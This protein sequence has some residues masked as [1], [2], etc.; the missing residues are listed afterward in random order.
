MRIRSALPGVRTPGG[1]D[2][3]L[4][5]AWPLILSNGCWALQISLNRVLLSRAG[6]DC[7]GAAT[8]AAMLYWTPICLLQG[9]ASYSATFVAQYHG[10]GQPH[11]VGPSVWQALYFAVASGIAFLMLIPLAPTLIVLVGHPSALQEIE[12]T[13]FR[14]LAVNA[15]PV[16][17]TAAVSGFFVGRGESRTMLVVNGIGLTITGVLAYAWVS[18]R[19]GCPAW[20]VAG[21]GWAT[22]AG[23]TLSCLLALAWLFRP[24]HDALYATWSGRRLDLDLMSRLLSYGVPSGLMVAL[25]SLAATLFILIVGR[26]GQAELAATSIAFTINLITS[27][28]ALGLGQAVA[29]LVGQRLGED[30]PE[31][32]RRATW[33]GLELILI[34]TASVGV[35]FCTVPESLARSFR[36]EANAT[37]WADVMRHLPLLLRFVAVY[38]TVEG[39]MIVLSFALRG[40]GDTRF[41][42]AAALVLSCPVMVLPTWFAW[43]QGW[44]L[45]W[46]WTFASLYVHLLALTFLARFCRG[47][48]YLMRVIELKWGHEQAG[49]RYH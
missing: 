49:S 48:W 21:A 33:T 30:R 12:V 1:V 37:A 44:G 43:R 24:S 45:Y 31:L 26:L 40:A 8:A 14:C 35:L 22:V 17:V 15:L 7:I 29:V 5:L 10:A 46:S 39:A 34:Y 20:G 36:V 18:G 4:R 25:D 47:K 38:S 6:S 32:A 27:L 2:E 42:T 13:Y 19:W 23:S 11:R 9:V 3:L 16:L 28:P 41:V